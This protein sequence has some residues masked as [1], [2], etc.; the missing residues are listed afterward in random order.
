MAINF[1]QD[2]DNDDDDDDEIQQPFLQTP[3]L[4]EN[5][6]NDLVENWGFVDGGD[7]IGTGRSTEFVH[8]NGTS[9]YFE[10]C[11]E[12]NPIVNIP[13]SSTL[14]HSRNEMYWHTVSYHEIW[15]D[16]EEENIILNDHHS[17]TINVSVYNYLLSISF[18]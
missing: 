16:D 15:D 11:L 5:I 3:I 17:W 1:Y 2:M 13:S 4:V 7:L 6:L 18:N 14:F 9:V 8:S 12:D 10:E